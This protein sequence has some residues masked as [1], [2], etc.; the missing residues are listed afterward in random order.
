MLSAPATHTCISCVSRSYR[1]TA[2]CHAA[3][4]AAA[5]ADDTVY[6]APP[7]VATSNWIACVAAATRTR[8][9]YVE[10]VSSNRLESVMP[11]MDAS[12]KVMTAENPV[13]VRR[14]TGSTGRDSSRY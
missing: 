6:V 4:L 9:E 10:L 2:V 8:I 1:T 14:G 12:W 5:A 3:R 11:G 7:P 13:E